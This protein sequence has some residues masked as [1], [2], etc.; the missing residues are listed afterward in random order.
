MLRS[1]VIKTLCLINLIIGKYSNSY[2]RVS[3]KRFCFCKIWVISQILIRKA[4]EKVCSILAK[5][6]R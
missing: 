6:G 1:V 4:T 3:T 5:S 2:Q